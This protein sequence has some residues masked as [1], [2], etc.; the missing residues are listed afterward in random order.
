[1]KFR[2][3]S[4]LAA[5]GINMKDLEQGGAIVHLDENSEG[6]VILFPKLG[7][8]VVALHSPVEGVFAEGEEVTTAVCLAPGAY[9]YINI[10]RDLKSTAECIISTVIQMLF[11]IK[12][13]HK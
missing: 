11:Y 10:T 13:K 2:E 8:G 7:E 9:R 12:T 5:V 3:E 4:Y 6:G 1:M